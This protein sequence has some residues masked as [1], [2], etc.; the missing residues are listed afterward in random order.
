MVIQHNL[1]A[2]NSKTGLTKNKSALAKNIEKLSSGY[3]IN[4]SGDDAAGL[5]ISEG[6]RAIINGT[7]Q[8]ESNTQDGISLIQTAEGAMTEI[9]SMLE[10]AYQLSIASANGTYNNQER[11][12]QQ[13]ELEELKQEINRITEYTN[14]NQIPLLK[15]TTD[16]DIYLVKYEGTFPD[17]VK[18]NDNSMV[19]N[20]LSG[21][22]ETTETFTPDTGSPTS[23]QI[24]HQAA[25]L[26]FSAYT[27]TTAQMNDLKKGGFYT[28]CFTCNNHYSI[29][30]T[31]GTGNS[32]ESSGSHYI[33]NI[34]IDG[35]NT[36]EDLVKAI[37]NGTDNGYPAGHYTKLA[38]DPTNSKTLIVYDDRSSKPEPDGTT[39]VTG[40]WNSSWKNQSFNI[41]KTTCPDDGKIGA[42]IAYEGDIITPWDI[43]LQV[44]PSQ[45][46]IMKVKLP[47]TT[48]HRLGITSISVSTS[49]SASMATGKIKK[50]I[51]YLSGERGRMGAYQNALEHTYSV[52]TNNA[53]NLITAESR[54]RDTDMADE[55]T[56]FTKNN[57]L[58]QAAQSMLSQ[59]NAIPN[60]IL[61]L[62]Q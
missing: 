8:A 2:L 13:E 57:I 61:S 19:N 36:A 12:I 24:E 4:R 47:N 6:L 33:F 35:I 40:T 49:Q 30:F 62:L 10:R 60:N 38:I 18:N 39:G 50:A 31:D 22:Y 53:E 9:H 42:G 15:G 32:M 37:V 48:H 59:A 52:L 26:D 5:A 45:N 54:I 44:G 11:S 34:G 17:W 27:G 51:E 21:V 46:E 23:Y 1:P 41:N 14:F 55:I 43:E 16:P 7:Q 3:R 20:Q 58:L 56:S 28:T 25:R 29:R